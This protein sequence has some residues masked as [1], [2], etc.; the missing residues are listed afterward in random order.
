MLVSTSLLLGSSL[1]SRSCILNWMQCASRARAQMLPTSSLPLFLYTRRDLCVT[2][3]RR[4]K[5]STEDQDIGGRGGV[6]TLRHSLS[7]GEALLQRLVYHP[8]LR[9]EVHDVWCSP[10]PLV[11][12]T[13]VVGLLL[14]GLQGVV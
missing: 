14:R 1:L 8:R 6:C 11:S 9:G 12:C 10:S 13:W 7:G 3:L 5:R 2:P 4:I